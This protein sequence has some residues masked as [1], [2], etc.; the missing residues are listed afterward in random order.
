MSLHLGSPGFGCCLGS[1]G[2]GS[3]ESA[4]NK[5]C[6]T[7]FVRVCPS[8]H[9]HAASPTAGAFTHPQR[10]SEMRKLLLPNCYSPAG[11]R[12][13]KTRKVRRKR[14]RMLIVTSLHML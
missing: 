6:A 1:V 3:G 14:R 11:G 8:A 2:L 4:C 9:A 13:V 5:H 10:E 12:D 7:C